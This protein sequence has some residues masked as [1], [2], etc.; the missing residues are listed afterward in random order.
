MGYL[1]LPRMSEADFIAAA[2]ETIDDLIGLSTKDDGWTFVGEEKGVRIHKTH[3]EDN[4]VVMVRGVTT[5]KAD[6]EDILKCTET[7]DERNKW[8][9]MFIKGT[10]LKDLDDSHQILHLQF[11]VRLF[12]FLTYVFVH[13]LKFFF[14]V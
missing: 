4:P 5:I 3:S 6:A 13:K 1:P 10:Y 12:F 2:D 14:R 9:E 8:D 11:K 7:L